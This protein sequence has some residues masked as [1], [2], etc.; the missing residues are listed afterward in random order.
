MNTAEEYSI[1]GVSR[2][3][4]KTSELKS[5][6]KNKENL[7]ANICP[8]PKA[9]E[10]SHSKMNTV[11]INTVLTTDIMHAQYTSQIS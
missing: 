10:E 7:P 6:H 4:G 5:S 3:L 8:E 1:Q 9:F 2:M 11:I